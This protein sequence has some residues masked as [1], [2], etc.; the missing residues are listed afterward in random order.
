MRTFLAVEVPQKE[1][2]VISDFVLSAAKHELPVKWVKFE[3]LH[4]TLKFLG[5]IDEEK[6]AEITPVI[7][8][9][10]KRHSPFTV[11]MEGLG[12]F[13][14]PRNPRVIWIG[15]TQGGE[16]LCTIADALEKELA[17]SGFKVESRFHPHLTIGRVKKRCRVED[18]LARDI[19]TEPFEVTSVV[20]F[21]STLKPE[22]PTYDQLHKFMLR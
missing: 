14:N 20:L 11:K 5:E 16:E 7:K 4:I 6:K 8:D 13:P 10:C 17:P 18:I 21:E 9:I 22:G 2:K 15:V 1:R 12:C 3:N 19:Y